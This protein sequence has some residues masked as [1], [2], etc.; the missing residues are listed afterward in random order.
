M[1]NAECPNC[2]DEPPKLFMA[3][4]EDIRAAEQRFG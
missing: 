3:R 2:T 1:K 4:E